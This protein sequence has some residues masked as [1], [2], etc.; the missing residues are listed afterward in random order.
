MADCF[1]TSVHV[2][3]VVSQRCERIASRCHLAARVFQLTI[4]IL[5]SAC[6]PTAKPGFGVRSPAPRSDCSAH[7]TPRLTCA[8][9]TT[10]GIAST[11]ARTSSRGPQR[12]PRRRSPDRLAPWWRWHPQPAM[13]VVPGAAPT[14]R[15]GPPR[16]PYGRRCGHA[17]LPVARANRPATAALTSHRRHRSGGVPVGQPPTTWRRP[18]P[19]VGVA[20]AVG[21]RSR[22]HGRRGQCAVAPRRRPAS[23]L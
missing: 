15:V 4:R 22:R 2:R 6:S 11:C 7:S 10:Q 12:R 17:G 21:S 14:L 5:A 19:Q 8:D 23:C 3:G 13:V 9:S 20:R 18:D 1:L 16:W